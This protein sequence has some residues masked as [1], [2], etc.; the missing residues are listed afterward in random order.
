MFEHLTRGTQLMAIYIHHKKYFLENNIVTNKGKVN[1]GLQ[2]FERFKP[3]IDYINENKPFECGIIEAIYCLFHG[4]SQKPKCKICDIK[5]TSFDKFT[6]GYSVYCSH[7]C[8][9]TDIVNLGIGLATKDTVKRKLMSQKAASVRKE[10]GSYNFSENHKTNMSVSAKMSMYKKRKTCKEK[11]GVEN[12]GVLGGYT[13]KRATEYIKIFIE[14]RNID[15]D[16]CFFED[17][18]SNKFEY[19]QMINLPGRSKKKYAKYD[20]VV[21]KDKESAKMKNPNDI[22]LVLE[23][24]GPWHYTLQEVLVDPYSLA[25][26]YKK[27]SN[28]KTKKDVLIYDK[29]KRKHLI[30][31]QEY[32]TY[33]ERTDRLMK[34]SLSV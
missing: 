15:I 31:V 1:P 18:E 19:F 2:R 8:Y 28:K 7:K 6:T 4:I 3:Y 32:Y 27:S 12:P 9:S 34:G 26:P 22:I 20:L 25:V 33:W 5:G 23:Y 17:K 13:S 29:A 11:Y 14:E 10:N 16:C 30:N 24:N 21:F